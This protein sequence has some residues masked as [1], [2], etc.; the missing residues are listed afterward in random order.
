MADP[1]LALPTGV[2]I[3]T[4]VS[5]VGIGGGILW[6]PFML[7]LL[8]LSPQAAVMTSLL[9]QAVGMG[10]SSIAYNRRRRIDYRLAGLLLIVTVPGIAAGAGLTRALAPGQIALCL[11]LLTLVT[12]FLFVSANQKYD[13]PGRPR[14]APGCLRPYLGLVSLMA[15]ASGMLSVSIGEWLVPV[16]RSKLTL[17]MHTAVATSI[18]TVFGT[19]VVGAALHFALGGRPHWPTVAWAVPGVFIGGQL[20]P[21]LAERINER[22]LKEVFIFL[23]TLIGIH[24]TYNA[25]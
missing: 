22:K 9:I 12:A 13:D 5:A 11:G 19:C 1:W 3:A 6:M 16:M 17:R 23:L 10:S 24:L 21:R 7:I 8:R 14:I 2:A 4:V 25:F 18:V 15:V 20:G